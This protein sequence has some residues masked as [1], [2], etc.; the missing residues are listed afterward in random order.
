MA[1]R[2]PPPI[3]GPAAIILVRS[4]RVATFIGRHS[5]F[6]IRPGTLCRLSL[7]STL[8]SNVYVVHEPT[9]GCRGDAQCKFHRGRPSCGAG[10]FEKTRATK[11]GSVANMTPYMDR[12]FFCPA[13]PPPMAWPAAIILVRS[14]RVI[15]LIVRHSTFEIRSGTLCRLTLW[16]DALK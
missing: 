9:P 13:Y 15:T 14:G 8:L 7:C 10:I 4:G 3:A 5:S 1:R 11:F 16:F 2:T 6:K 12:R